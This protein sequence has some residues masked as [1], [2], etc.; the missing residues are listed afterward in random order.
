MQII[1]VFYH[2]LQ[3][4]T[5]ILKASCIASKDIDS[6]EYTMQQGYILRPRLVNSRHLQTVLVSAV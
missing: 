4:A 6:T 3:F 2:I 1:L 5:L